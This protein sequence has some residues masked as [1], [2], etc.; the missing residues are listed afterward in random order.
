MTYARIEVDK[1]VF[2]KREKSVA[3]VVAKKYGNDVVVYAP[4]SRIIV[5]SEREVPM[6]V[7]QVKVQILVPCWV[8]TKNFCYPTEAYGYITQIER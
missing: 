6:T 3:I 1:D 7:N 2:E 4:K 5:E 8:F